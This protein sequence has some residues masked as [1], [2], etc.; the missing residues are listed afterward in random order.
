MWFEKGYLH[1]RDWILDHYHQ[2][3]LNPETLLIVLLID[4]ANQNKTVLTNQWLAKQ[5]KMTSEALDEAI[6]ELVELQ[7]LKIE[8]SRNEIIF[9]IDAIFSMSN[10][11][12][13]VDEGLLKRFEAE[14]GRPLSQNEL[15]R[16]NELQSKHPED[17]IIYALKEAF[18]QGKLSM[19]YIERVIHNAK[20]KA[21]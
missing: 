11:Y 4:Y 1:R 8:T 5:S 19:T 15:A 14:F 7:I 12:E 13:Y 18:V 21:S 10:P 9:N 16:L 3:R 2:L 6:S 20:S 17:I